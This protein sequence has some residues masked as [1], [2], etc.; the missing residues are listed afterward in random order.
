MSPKS[1]E[2]THRF[3]RACQSLAVDQTPV[4]LMR[5]AG[6]YLPEYRRIRQQAG[7]FLTLCKNPELATEV[8]LQPVY[9]FDMDAAILFSDIL[10]VPEAMGMQLTFGDGEGP[11]LTPAVRQPSDLNRLRG[12]EPENQLHY[13]LQT[14]RMIRHALDDKVPLIGF[15][16]SPWTLATYM[17][18]GGSSKSFRHVKGMLF[19]QPALLQQLLDQLSDVVACYLNAQIEQGVQA[20]QIFDTWG[21]VLGPR[22]FDEFSLRSMQ[23]VI[24]Q[25]RREGTDGQRVPIILFA[26]GCGSQLEQML[27]SGCDVLGLDWT[28]D[29]GLARQRVGGRVALQGNLDPAVL[30]ASPERLRQEVQRLL[31]AYGPHPGHIFNL[32]HGMAPDMEPE[33]VTALVAAVREESRRLLAGQA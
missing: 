26:K 1:A 8:T 11:L 27:E 29:L 18:E 33:Q 30:Y 14:V 12:V 17:V 10:V 9:R 28:T 4:W 7:D 19:D 22:E 23:R 13:V 24:G 2:P 6:R 5:Q 31:Q 16:G 20:I 32:G 21:G 15:S 3:L 25:L